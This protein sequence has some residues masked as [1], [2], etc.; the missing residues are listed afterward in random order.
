MSDSLFTS[1]RDF[2][3][4]SFTFL[5]AVGTLPLFLGHTAR[6][7]AGEEPKRKKGGDD[8]ILVVVQLAG[9]NDGLNTIVPYEMDPY[10]KARPQI[11]VPKKDVLKLENGLGL[12]PAATGLKELFD[13]GQMA[14]VQGV[15]YPNPNRSHFTSMDIWHT[16][17]PNLKA[18]EGWIGRYFDS[19]CKGSDPD[20]E[21]IS[22]IAMTKETP[23]AMQGERFTPLSFES[24]DS[25][26]WRGPARDAS[27]AAA[28][29]KLNNIDGDFPNE[30]HE[31]AKYLQRAALKA[32]VGADEIRAA[33]GSNIAGRNA[34]RGFARGGGGQL[35]Q[36]LALVARLIAA[37]M[38]TRIYYVSMGGF[39]THT[40]QSGRH[41]R[42]MTEFSN[43]I[44]QF[45][46]TLEDQKLLDRVLV[47]SFSEF[48]RRVQE[49]ASGGTDHGE[50]APMFL[51]GSAVKPGIHEKHPDLTKLRR[52]DLEFGCDFRRV[53]ATVLTEWLK[54]KPEAVLGKG[55]Q[56]L[57]VLKSLV[58]SK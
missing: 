31:L 10:Y 29:R 54:A 51:F 58:A 23:L 9:G 12:H 1:R 8:R 15:G 18:H 48:G 20:P 5:S 55:F 4:G 19:C 53:Y 7:L 21:P 3:A 25:L 32:Q 30:E 47:L 41:Q 26:A 34:R 6:A 11:A 37:D 38:P 57:K 35:A 22:G 46:E 49:N 52:G 13:E 44:K 17:D 24:P 27:A 33:A 28:F 56:P 36:Q 16:A 14:V 39:D 2:L 40:G 50:A 45:I 42:L 43:G